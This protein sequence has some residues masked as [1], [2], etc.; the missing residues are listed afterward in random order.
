M[1][2]KKP[3]PAPKWIEKDRPVTNRQRVEA[4][5]A[6][7]GVEIAEAVAKSLGPRLDRLDR[8]V[9][10]MAEVVMDLGRRVECLENPAQ[11]ARELSKTESTEP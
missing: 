5:Q 6:Q 11:N 4:L 10:E 7:K 2:T 9:D 3:K 1:K 8:V